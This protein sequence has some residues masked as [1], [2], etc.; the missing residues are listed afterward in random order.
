MALAEYSAK[1]I[2]QCGNALGEG[3]IWHAPSQRLYWFDIDAHKLLRAKADGE[4][5]GQWQRQTPISV[6]AI[7][8]AHSFVV[9]GTSG[10]HM[11]DINNGF[12][13]LHVP[14]EPDENGNRTNDGRVGPGGILWISTMSMTTP[15]TKNTGAIYG[16]RGTE[17][18]R[19]HDGLHIPN[20]ICFSPD[21]DKAYFTDTRTQKIMQQTLDLQTGWP[22]SAP[23]E[24]ADT[25]ALPGF[26]DGS[27]VD[28][29]GCLWNA[30]WEG[31][32]VVRLTPRGDVDKIVHV[33]TP[34]VTCPAFGGRYLC[35]M[36]ITTAG[37]GA[38]DSDSGAGDLYAIELPFQGLDERIFQP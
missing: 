23:E 13:A 11:F 6:A 31:G 9:A 19:L 2:C 7:I 14:L 30:R 17:V 27:V 12:G 28:A 34:K 16:V 26:P 35:T 8:D 21:G 38:V 36:F 4:I 5:D 29:D 15:A 32:M 37:G 24:F 22:K 10:L 18:R 33:P 1:A 3:P 20:S 25:S